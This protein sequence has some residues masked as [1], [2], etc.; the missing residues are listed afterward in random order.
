MA[1]T[2]HVVQHRPRSESKEVGLK[3]EVHTLRAENQ[4][5]KRENARLR[6]ENEKALS[7]VNFDPPEEAPAAAGSSA[8]IEIPN[9]VGCPTNCG[10]DLKRIKMAGKT[11]VA[12]PSCHWR[13]VE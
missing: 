1:R 11:I 12:C 4:K 10:V 6:R 2:T 8:L 13:K 7:R 3:T 5:L 9:P